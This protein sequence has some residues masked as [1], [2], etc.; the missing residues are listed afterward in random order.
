MSDKK[1]RYENWELCSATLASSFPRKLNVCQLEGTTELKEKYV[2]MQI[3]E[4]EEPMDNGNQTFL[5]HF[6]QLLNANCSLQENIQ[7]YDN[8][9]HSG[10]FHFAHACFLLS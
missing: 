1:G 8:S 2:S 6:A 9:M 7:D 5:R 10:L 3:Q 4:H